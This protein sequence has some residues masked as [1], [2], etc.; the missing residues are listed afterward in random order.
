[1]ELRNLVDQ[2]NK[3]TGWVTFKAGFDVELEFVPK[4]TLEAIQRRCTRTVYKRHQP[5]EEVN[6]EKLNKELANFIRGWKG[7]D[8]ALLK[9]LFPVKAGTG[10]ADDAE[11][12]CDDCDEANRLYM[13]KNCYGFGD[14]VVN[15]ITEFETLRQDQ[16]EAERK[17]SGALSHTS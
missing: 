3:V 4:A 9:K 5:V 10:L 12:P 7:F 2:E 14:F 1:M 17:N 16:A 15:S 6:E 13:L 8:G 11:I